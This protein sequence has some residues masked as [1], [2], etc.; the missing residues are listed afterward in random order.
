MIDLLLGF[1]QT[2][3]VVTRAITIPELNDFCDT[4]DK[5]QGLAELVDKCAL[6]DSYFLGP[7]IGWWEDLTPVRTVRK[8]KEP[9]EDLYSRRV[10]LSENLLTTQMQSKFHAF[11]LLVNIL[12]HGKDEF[13]TRHGDLVSLDLDR[14]RFKSTAPITGPSINYT[15]CYT[16]YMDQWVYDT[17]QAVGPSQP[18]DNRLGMLMKEMLAYE[19]FF[20]GLWDSRLAVA[21]DTRVEML[22]NCIDGCIDKWGREN[23]ILNEPMTM[24]SKELVEYFVVHSEYKKNRNG[25]Q[26]PSNLDFLDELFE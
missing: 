1:G 21:L 22:L 11:Y 13:I 16:C 8:Y 12:R 10:E 20:Q 5:Q 6:S 26:G 17:F 4:T 19:K 23:V 15:W 14:S 7:M 24:T 2:A 3:P 18:V 25:Q 9:V